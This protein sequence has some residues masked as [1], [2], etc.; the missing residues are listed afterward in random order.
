MKKTDI[1]RRALSPDQL[2]AAY[3][4]NVGTMANLR[5]K[6]QGPKYFKVGKKVVYF[7][8]DIEAWIRQH[9]VL[10]QDSERM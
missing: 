7:V 8:E 4:L 2:Y 3:G 10:T 5:N 9:P 1:K 6:N